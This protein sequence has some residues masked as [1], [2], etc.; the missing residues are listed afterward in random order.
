MAEPNKDEVNPPP[1][2][3][4]SKTSFDEETVKE[5]LDLTGNEETT[6]PD[7]V[8]SELTKVDRVAKTDDEL[9]ENKEDKEAITTEKIVAATEKIEKKI[10]AGVAA[11]EDVEELKKQLQFYQ[12]LFGE[13]PPQA[14]QQQPQINQ[15]QQN[16][17]A[18]A[19]QQQKSILD[20][21]DV[22]QEELLGLLS[23]E[24][25]RAVP[26]IKKFI[27][28]AIVL[29]QHDTMQK[30]Q[31]QER[32]FNYITGVQKAFYEKYEDLSEER[33]RPLV[34]F[35][36]DQVHQE[37]MSKGITKYPHELIDDI[38][39][40]AMHLKEQL[41][42]NGIANGDSVVTKPK[43]VIKQGEVGG[44]KV[45]PPPKEQLTT[46]QKEMFDLLE[47]Q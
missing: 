25:E 47:Q 38:G 41:V 22:T 27:A 19:Q 10:E 21:V 24:P 29:A 15:Q 31:I 35:A 14:Q 30:Q 32:Q 5:A 39:K 9:K 16:N 20:A 34:K 33:F 26:V 7:D 36:G 42:A 46:D 17:Q 3:D 45:T 13:T 6:K 1:T 23:G 43:Q 11:T 28:T 40:R 12:T 37:Y 18:Q 44:T 8:V 2:E 4:P